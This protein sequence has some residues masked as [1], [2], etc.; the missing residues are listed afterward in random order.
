M[1]AP[2]LDPSSES[3]T[4]ASAARAELKVAASRNVAARIRTNFIISPAL[5]VPRTRASSETR[6]NRSHRPTLRL[7]RAA[8]A[9][10]LDPLGDDLLGRDVTDLAGEVDFVTL[11]LAGV[12]DRDLHAVEAEHLDERDL[13][14]LDL[15]LLDL[16]R[17]ALFVPDLA[18][19]L[20]GQPLAVRFEVVGV[21]LL[22][23]LAVEIRLPLAGDGGG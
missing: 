19:R 10:A 8:G 17:V 20:T 6:R 9:V 13:V 14:P 12:S 16:D 21:L 4:S 18:G 3:W 2:V 5:R 23:D 1:G 15:A 22:T 7:G 11:D